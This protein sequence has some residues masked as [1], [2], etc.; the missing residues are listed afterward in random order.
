MSVN[1]PMTILIV[2]D[3]PEEL[4]K[5]KD[6]AKG[7]DDIKII[8]VTNSS[9]EALKLAEDH[10]P[11]VIVL[12]LELH[13][14]L[15]SGIHFLNEL[16]SS[17]ISND[18]FIFLTIDVVAEV[19]LKIARD[20]GVTLTFSKKQ[21]DYSVGMV[22]D[23]ALQFRDAKGKMNELARK[24]THEDREEE[25]AKT[26]E[27]IVKHIERELDLIGISRALK[28]RYY[29]VE[30]I[31][32]LVGI[33]ID[34]NL[35]QTTAI[36]HLANLY[37]RSGSAITRTMQTAIRSAWKKSRAEDLMLYYTDRVSYQTGIPA[38]SEFLRYYAKKVRRMMQ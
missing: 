29:L 26:K 7:N 6:Y 28:G 31:Y 17:L 24:E 38:T 11:E 2:E 18:P 5:F 14:G 37:N 35:R 20:A 13:N 16:P 23:M 3:D 34:L 4:L 15:G 33:N 27:R 32:F 25:I 19:V 8:G 22:F 9:Y 12:D 36:E 10:L 21:R 30:G 1:K